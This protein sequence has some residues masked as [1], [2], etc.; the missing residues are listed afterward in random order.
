[1]S[2]LP[3]NIKNVF[4]R[5]FVYFMEDSSGEGINIGWTGNK[6]LKWTRITQHENSGLKLLAIIPGTKKGTETRTEGK[7]HDHFRYCPINR[8]NSTE[9]FDS[10]EVRPYVK[11]LL[12][13]H[14]ATDDLTLATSLGYLA[15]DI[16]RPEAVLAR[17]QKGFFLAEQDKAALR[18]NWQ[19]PEI[20]I[21]RVHY[22][23][24]PDFIGLS[25][26]S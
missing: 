10:K 3:E 6:D 17:R 15:W 20:I 24:K 21:E 16:I 23:F 1:M 19:T 25:L 2:I 13:W 7:L 22:A 8:G 26:M 18:D 11:K 14:L 5:G 4:D 9:V 12:E